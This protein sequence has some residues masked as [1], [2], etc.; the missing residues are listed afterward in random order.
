M[1]VYFLAYWSGYECT[2]VYTYTGMC[3]EPGAGYIC[4]CTCMYTVNHTNSPLHSSGGL[5]GEGSLYPLLP[6]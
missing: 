6:P 5:Q 2:G 1:H 4:A 3:E